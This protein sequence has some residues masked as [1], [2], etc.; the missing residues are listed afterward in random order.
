MRVNRVQW[1]AGLEVKVTSLTEVFPLNVS[2]LLR[3]LTDLRTDF[4]NISRDPNSFFEVRDF[5]S[6][7]CEGA[8]TAIETASLKRR[9]NHVLVG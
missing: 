8:T 3:H 4:L 2:R 5:S 6:L 9:R 1:D 7:S